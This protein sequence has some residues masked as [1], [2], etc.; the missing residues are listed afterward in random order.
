MNH[1]FADKLDKLSKEV[2]GLSVHLTKKAAVIR[3]KVDHA[4]DQKQ[5]FQEVHFIR[6]VTN[7]LQK[8]NIAHDKPASNIK[9]FKYSEQ[10]RTPVEHLDSSDNDDNNH[11][12][13]INSKNTATELGDPDGHFMFP[14]VNENDPAAHNFVCKICKKV[15]HDPYDLRN[16]DT[17][18]KMEFYH[19]LVCE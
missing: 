2:H 14:K 3:E 7:D 1:D 9:E 15:F 19:C 6:D 4:V 10:F 18:H 17:Q 8:C 16:H 12:E 13:P 5:R 11:P